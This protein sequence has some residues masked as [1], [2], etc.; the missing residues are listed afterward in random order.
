MSIEAVQDTPK[1]NANGSSAAGSPSST[2]SRR[3]RLQ[4]ITPDKAEGNMNVLIV[5]DE[6]NILETMAATVTSIGYQAFT[7]HNPR[8]A[9]RQ[10]KEKDIHAMF[11]DMRLG[12]ESGLDFL[13]SV[14]NE[15]IQ[16]PAIVFTAYSSVE[17]AIDALKSGATDYIQKPFYPKDI[18]QM[19]DRIHEDRH[20][21]AVPAK[22][23][24]TDT[25]KRSTILFES[26]QES[27]QKT[28]AVA[29]KAASSEAN[30][31]ILGQS[32]TGKTVLARHLH[33]LSS[34]SQE[35]FVT[36][37][38]PSL[39]RDL[40]ESELFGHMKGAFTGAVSDTWG[41]VA[42]A[43]KGTLF[44][45]EIGELPQEIQPKLLR[46]LQEK[47]YERVGE[48][49]TRSSNVRVI[50]ATNRNLEAEVEAGRFRVD[51]YYRLKVIELSLPPLVER[52]SDI[53]PLAENYLAYFAGESKRPNLHFSKEAQNT[54]LEYGWPGNLREMRNV[55]ERASILSENDEI[56]PHHLPSSLQEREE[57]S[58]RPGH[59]VPL[60]RLEEEHI[61]LI[62][63]KAESLEQAARILEIDTATLYRKR[64]RMGLA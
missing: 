48:T 64:K 45:D 54:L 18:K 46:L 58:I 9:M 24:P 11:L 12:K 35:P 37:N 42:A 59:S 53:L 1:S 10:L 22:T 38:C 19:L 30:L 34:R 44:L 55:V 13:K 32:G 8:Q 2:S 20:V 52:P 61:R 23:A 3:T 56:G 6:K 47:E 63:E 51:L 25:K 4:S 33:S 15:G 14:R 7:A 16:L 62:L 41:K 29:E 60:A 50:A 39:S 28:L 49:Q 17:S 27:V 57:S 36:V 26:R 5:D 21:E 31:L 40:L 43:H